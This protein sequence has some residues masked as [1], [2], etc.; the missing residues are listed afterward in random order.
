VEVVPDMVLFA[1]MILMDSDTGTAMC[2]GRTY[3]TTGSAPE[4][5]SAASLELIVR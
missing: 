4:P 5:L 2:L 1:H 3:L